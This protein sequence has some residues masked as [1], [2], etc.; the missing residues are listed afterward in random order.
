MLSGLRG[1]EI[2][3]SVHL[4]WF[5]LEVPIKDIDLDTEMSGYPF[6]F[7]VTQCKIIDIRTAFQTRTVHR[8]TVED[9]EFVFLSE[10]LPPLFHLLSAI[11]WQA[12]GSHQVLVIVSSLKNVVSG[13]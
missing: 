6:L 5:L 8:N 12:A 4:V 1:G 3:I 13:L 9:G 11:L 7:E 2:P 10:S